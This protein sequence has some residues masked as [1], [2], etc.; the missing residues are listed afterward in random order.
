MP[1]DDTTEVFTRFVREAGPR[2]KQCLIAALGG[3]AGR[4]ATAEAL[5]WAWEHWPRLQTMEDPAGYL[6]RLTEGVFIAGL[7]RGD[8]PRRATPSSVAPGLGGSRR[9]EPTFPAPAG[10]SLPT[11]RSSNGSNRPARPERISAD[12]TSTTG[13][14]RYAPGSGDRGG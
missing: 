12:P 4:E 9:A 6:Y 5:A 11:G 2:L 1:D 14:E 7:E 10:L 3:E 13:S 8:P